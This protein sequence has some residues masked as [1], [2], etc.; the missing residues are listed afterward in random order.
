MTPRLAFF[1]QGDGR[2][3]CGRGTFAERALPDPDGKASFYAND[4]GLRDPLP[5]K[6]PEAVEVYETVR[7]M[8]VALG[9]NGAPPGGVGV[10]WE[11]LGRKAFAAAFAR[12]E[13]WFEG[14]F[15]EKAVPVAVKNG[16]LG[17]G[18]MDT[19][20]GRLSGES[21]ALRAYGMMGDRG[22]FA[23]ATPE[24]LFRLSGDGWLETMALA[25]TA[26]PE[27]A[28]AMAADPKAQH[29]HA[30]VADDLAERLGEFGDVEI[31]ARSLLNVGT[32]CHLRTRL[33]VR[34]DDVARSMDRALR[35]LHP[36]PAL[37]VSPRTMANIAFL[38]ELRDASGVP[39]AFGAPFGL[40]EG[41]RCEMLVA[42]RAV[43][44][45]GARVMIPAGC[46]VVEESDLENEWEEARLKCRTVQ[47]FFGL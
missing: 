9:L 23:G 46:G 14:G 16:T 27:G 37:G 24:L 44:W 33:R 7:E 5:W 39:G 2:V 21:N 47:E 19:V 22:G 26:R 13:G 15:I 40:A 17:S 20:L 41:G 36:T 4:F 45:D 6:V 42:I 35:T 8:V 38:Q 30:V 43:F 12:C 34:V 29:E 3:V 1:E 10:E 32:M 11:P 25:G 28:E 31:G 18:K